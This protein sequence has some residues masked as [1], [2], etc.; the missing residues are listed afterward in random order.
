MCIAGLTHVN[1]YT[2]RL[3]QMYSRFSASSSVECWTNVGSN[4]PELDH[5]VLTKYGPKIDF[6]KSGGNV[7]RVWAGGARVLR[8]NRVRGSYG[9]V[10][11]RSPGPWAIERL[12]LSSEI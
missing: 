5:R 2:G 11:W 9:F 4:W 6:R 8:L 7:P 3:S 1:R 12:H 10:Q